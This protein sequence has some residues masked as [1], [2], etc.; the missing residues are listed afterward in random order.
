MLIVMNI[1]FRDY[2]LPGSYR[3]IIVKPTNTTWSLH[4]YNDPTESLELSDLDELEG[5]KLASEVQGKLSHQLIIH[6][7]FLTGC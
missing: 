7:M 6:F 5:I 4:E 3:K 1:C 2:S